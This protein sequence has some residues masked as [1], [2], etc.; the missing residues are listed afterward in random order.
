MGVSL[1]TVSLES[2]DIEK[3]VTTISANS[4]IEENQQ[5]PQEKEKEL[6]LKWLFKHTQRKLMKLL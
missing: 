5:I 6:I 1:D 2:V 3:D 4:N